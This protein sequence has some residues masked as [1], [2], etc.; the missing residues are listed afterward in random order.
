MFISTY[1]ILLT[2]KQ[3]ISVPYL[4]KNTRESDNSDWEN[5]SAIYQTKQSAL[6]TGVVFEEKTKQNKKIKPGSFSIP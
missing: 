2:I 1:F 6:N 3:N 5:Q 4:Y